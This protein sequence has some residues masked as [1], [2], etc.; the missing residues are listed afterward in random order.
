[1]LSFIFLAAGCTLAGNGDAGRFRVVVSF[2]SSS[3]LL[4][5]LLSLCCFFFFD[6]EAVAGTCETSDNACF[7]VHCRAVLSYK[8]RL[9]LKTS[10]YKKSL[11]R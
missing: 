2:S 7:I 11:T 10:A 9:F 5:E 6:T 8:A 3:E 4:S 1:M